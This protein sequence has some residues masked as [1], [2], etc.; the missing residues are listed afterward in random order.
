MP[1]VQ[2]RPCLLFGQRRADVGTVHPVAGF[3]LARLAG[4]AC[5]IVRFK[6]KGGGGCLGTDNKSIQ[7]RASGFSKLGV[8]S[9]SHA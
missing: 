7:Y 3:V 6:S 8:R 2:L 9:G 1:I 5:P 4:V